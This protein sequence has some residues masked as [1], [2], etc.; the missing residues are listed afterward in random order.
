MSTHLGSIVRRVRTNGRPLALTVTGSEGVFGILRAIVESSPLDEQ[1]KPIP[2]R[3][4][5]WREKAPYGTVLPA[6]V[7]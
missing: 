3:S 1:G 4:G 6:A 5:I 7:W 2:Q